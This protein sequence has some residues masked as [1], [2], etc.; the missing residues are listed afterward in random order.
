VQQ[1]GVK[2][3]VYN[4]VARKMYDIKFLWPRFMKSDY[5]MIYVRIPYYLHCLERTL[6]QLREH[7]LPIVIF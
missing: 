2:Y 1:V 6:W 4:L 3:C 7:T 5:V